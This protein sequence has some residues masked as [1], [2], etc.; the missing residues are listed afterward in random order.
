MVLPVVDRCQKTPCSE[1]LSMHKIQQAASSYTERPT[2]HR[3]SAKLSR[4]SNSGLLSSVSAGTPKLPV[5]PLGQ[6]LA[7]DGKKRTR[8]VVTLQ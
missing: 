3:S 5:V 4:D 7:L 2:S 6:K 8:S 1:E